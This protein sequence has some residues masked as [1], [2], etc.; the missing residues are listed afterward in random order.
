MGTNILTVTVQ[1]LLLLRTEA[2]IEVQWDLMVVYLSCFVLSVVAAGQLFASFFRNPEHTPV[3]SVIVYCV[4]VA[5]G[6]SIAECDETSYGEEQGCLVDNKLTAASL[7]STVALILGFRQIVIIIND[8]GRRVTWQNIHTGKAAAAGLTRSTNDDFTVSTTLGMIVADAFLYF[9]LAWYISRVA[10]SGYRWYFPVSKGYWC[11]STVEETPIPVDPQDDFEP[12]VTQCTQELNHLYSVRG[13]TASITVDGISKGKFPGCSYRQQRVLDDIDLDLHPGQVLAVVGA[14]G[15]SALIRC[16]TGQL[17]PD[18]GRFYLRKKLIQPALYQYRMKIGLAPQRECL[19]ERL[20]VYEHLKLVGVLKNTPRLQLKA[21]AESIALEVDLLSLRN[22]RVRDLTPGQKK[23]LQ[24][25]MALLG[26]SYLAFLDEPTLDMDPISTGKIR[27]LIRRYKQR[28][29]I[30]ITTSS[31][32]EAELVGDRICM[33]QY[34]RLRCIGTSGFLKRRFGCGYHITMTKSIHPWDSHIPKGSLIRKLR[35]LTPSAFLRESTV[36]IKAHLPLQSTQELITLL[37]VLENATHPIHCEI[38]KWSLKM[39]GLEDIYLRLE[40]IEYRASCP[41]GHNMTEV[42]TLTICDGKRHSSGNKLE[43]KLHCQLCNYTLCIPCSV[44]GDYLEREIGSCSESVQASPSCGGSESMASPRLSTNVSPRV[45]EPARLN[46]FWQDSDF[47]EFLGVG[48]EQPVTPSIQVPD[49]GSAIPDCNRESSFID[50]T[51]KYSPPISH[52]P[53]PINENSPSTPSALGAYFPPTLSGLSFSKPLSRTTSSHCVHEDV[54]E[55]STTAAAT[56][57]AGSPAQDQFLNKSN[58]T[59]EVVPRRDSIPS[60]HPDDDVDRDILEYNAS[61]CEIP[62]EPQPV[63]SEQDD[64][65]HVDPNE[66]G[67]DQYSNCE[68]DSQEIEEVVRDSST[69]DAVVEQEPTQ[70]LSIKT[71]PELGELMVD[72]DLQRSSEMSSPPLPQLP[73]PQVDVPELPLNVLKKRIHGKNPFEYR[74]S[75]L[76]IAGAEEVETES[77]IDGNHTD[78]VD[79]YTAIEQQ[80]VA[81]PEEK[82]IETVFN[83]SSAVNTTLEDRIYSEGGNYQSFDYARLPDIVFS[84]PAQTKVSDAAQLRM[85]VLKR[86]RMT[87]NNGRAL[88]CHFV[89]PLCFV[90]TGMLALELLPSNDKM[91]PSVT[92]QPSVIGP[93]TDGGPVIPVSGP[94]FK[95]WNTTPCLGMFI[96]YYYH[97]WRLREKIPFRLALY[98][99]PSGLGLRHCYSRALAWSTSLP[100]IAWVTATPACAY[101]LDLPSRLSISNSLRPLSLSPR[102]TPGFLRRLPLPS[103]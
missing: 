99:V 24:V 86:Y 61:P 13:L 100:A 38:K 16:L 5:V 28:K 57:P 43:N 91:Y 63:S 39:N 103:L 14:S 12:V 74:Q 49:S 37:S 85:L 20:T 62:M 64:E 34:G 2:L 84:T 94:F 17:I 76:K 102:I 51:I 3:L 33:L 93:S 71:S 98:F 40:E 27:D 54:D 70:Q 72:S 69:P 81:Q 4:F 75:T 48:I 35:T 77:E 89:L 9:L 1:V 101:R 7:I 50:E 45:V 79:L 36:Q 90:V 22:R 67:E 73:P 8:E 44:A 52:A 26:D 25:A 66:G 32:A 31:V 30:V 68:N 78:S 96:V 41:A 82:D 59:D 55:V 80:E 46:H 15:K 65:I 19:F 6:A 21:Q 29:I 56:V 10:H 87:R 83:N 95:G 11:S 18:S 88:F 53:D 60:T 23:K 47:N 42:E 97:S 58:Y 92:L